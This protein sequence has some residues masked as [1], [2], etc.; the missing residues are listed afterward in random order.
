MY[1]NFGA[2]QSG[3]PSSPKSSASSNRHHLPGWRPIGNDHSKDLAFQP[4]ATSSHQHRIRAT[5]K[6]ASR[7]QHLADLAVR[8]LQLQ[9]NAHDQPTR[10]AVFQSPWRPAEASSTVR[11][12]TWPAAEP[13]FYIA[14]NPQIVDR[15]FRQLDPT[16]AG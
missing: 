12:T 16:R 1:M 7:P 9:I 14:A 6:S 10:S 3:A 4:K 8:R 11:S 2:P 15:Q 13:I 5:P